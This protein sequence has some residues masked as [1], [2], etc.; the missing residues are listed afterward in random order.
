MQ[1]GAPWEDILAQ[2]VSI[3]EGMQKEPTWGAIEPVLPV[4][5]DVVAPFPGGLEW[6]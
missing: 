6:D 1:G 3:A 2:N 4:R 5:L